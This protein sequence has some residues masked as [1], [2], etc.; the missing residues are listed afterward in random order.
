M[1]EAAEFLLDW[2][3]TDPEHPAL[4]TTAP[5]TSPENTYW[6]PDGYRA[7]VCKGSAMDFAITGSLFRAVLAAAERL[8]LTDDQLLPRIAAALDRLPKQAILPNGCLSEFGADVRGAEEPHRH[9][10]QLFA[11]TPGHDL[12]PGLQDGAR[13]VLRQ[14]GVTGTGWALAWKAKC[15]ARLGEGQQAFAHLDAILRPE[16]A[17]H[18]EIV[19]DGGGVYPN[20]LTSHPPMQMDANFGYGAAVLDMLVQATESRIQLLPALPEEW[21]CGRVRGLCLPGGG[22]LDVIWDG[23]TVQGQIRGSRRQSWT[24]VLGQH[25]ETISLLPD[26][27]AD[28]VLSVTLC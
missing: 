17:S 7:S 1:A 2:L 6:H 16:R 23:V 15:W 26:T 10:S 18:T 25:S 13:A 21:A 27:P 19:M 22:S 4:L 28:F 9:V 3:V 14:K 11:L 5:S 24:L 12:D 8:S 20:M